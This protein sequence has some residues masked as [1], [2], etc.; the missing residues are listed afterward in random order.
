MQRRGENGDYLACCMQMFWYVLNWEI[1]FGEGKMFLNYANEKRV[2]RWEETL[3][4]ECESIL[5][6]FVV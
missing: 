1:N 4:C 3:V 6:Y 5:R 2:F